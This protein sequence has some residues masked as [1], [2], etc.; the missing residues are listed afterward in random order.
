[1]AGKKIDTR[2]G[3]NPEP[4]GEIVAYSFSIVSLP[5]RAKCFG[6]LSLE[7]MHTNPVV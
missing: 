3:R 2:G 7:K 6:S 1:M 5:R 4:A